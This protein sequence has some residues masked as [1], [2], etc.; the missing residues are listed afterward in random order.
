MGDWL[1]ATIDKFTFR[2]PEDRLFTAEGIWLQPENGATVRLGVTDYV[3]QH[4]GDIAFVSTKPRGTRLALEEEFA[5]IETI[6]V[7]LS[8]PS[9]IT[10]TVVEVNAALETGPELVN[11]DPYGLGWLV[12]MD[13]ASWD[14][15]RARL[16]QP[17]A[18]LAVMQSQAEA[19]IRQP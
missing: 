11:K 4:S 18:Y 15:E 2:V 8:L 7:N 3:Q 14:T 5:A 1:E 16:L 12:V 9:P 10:G 17:A 19:E 6:K 13:A